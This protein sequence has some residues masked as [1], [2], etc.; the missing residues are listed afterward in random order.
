[1]TPTRDIVL[2]EADEAPN[3]TASGI[4][5]HE[6]WKT[7]PP[8]GTVKQVGPD[9]TLVKAGDRIVFERYGAVKVK[10][11]LRFCQERHIQAII[12]DGS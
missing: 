2:V 11:N 6:D 12:T 7:L 8:T 10:D 9:V 3:Q 4:L 5:I 1:M